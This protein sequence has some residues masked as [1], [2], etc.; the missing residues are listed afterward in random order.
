VFLLVGE[1]LDHVL[2][3]VRTEALDLGDLLGSS[4]R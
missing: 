2:S 1:P 4:P 3:T